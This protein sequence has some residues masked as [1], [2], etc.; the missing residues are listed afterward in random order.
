MLTRRTVFFLAVFA[1]GVVVCLRFVAIRPPAKPAIS[2]SILG[3]TKQGD[4]LCARVSLA[5][6]GRA[7]VWYNVGGLAGPGGWLAA[8]S[9]NGWH[10]REIGGSFDA[11]IGG[12]ILSSRLLRPGSNAVST[13]VLPPDTLRWE[14]GFRVRAASLRELAAWNLRSKWF[15]R[16]WPL[17]RLVLPDNKGPGQEIRT[18]PMELPLVLAPPDLRDDDR[19]AAGD[20]IFSVLSASGTSPTHCQTLDSFGWSLQDRGIPISTLPDSRQ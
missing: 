10:L 4:Q 9:P 20:G 14:A 11:Y 16:I 19:T 5:N 12:V 7:S 3:Y 1:V 8:E 18:G 15:A 17:C 6:S 13:I 2:V